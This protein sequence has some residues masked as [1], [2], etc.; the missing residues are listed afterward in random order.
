MALAETP[1]LNMRNHSFTPWAA[2]I[3]VTYN[4]GYADI[5]G[6]LERLLASPVAIYVID[7]WFSEESTEAIRKL[8]QLH[9]QRIT[10]IPLNKNYGIAFAINRG[11]EAARTDQHEYAMLF[12][13]DSLPQEGLMEEMHIVATR[14]SAG[15]K[16]VAAIGPRLYDPR[17]ST[18]FRFGLLRWGMWQRVGCTCGNGDLIRCEFLNSS[19]S[20]LFL[21]HWDQIG[22][23]REDFFIDHVETEWY[24]RVRHLGLECY[25]FC[26]PK[27]IDHH[28]GDSVCRYWLGKWR[29]MPRRSP[30]RHYTIVR[31]GI[32]MWR[33][34]HVPLSWVTNSGMKII[35][36]L[37]FFSLFDKEG[38]K[39]FD[40]IFKGICDGLFHHPRENGTI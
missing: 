2:C 5:S 35:F 30:L 27:H 9:P 23:F 21:R 10:F 40:F 38:K 1:S 37:V 13:Q 16:K 18:Y 26:S 4:P 14:L 24:M 15:N 22:P 12:D 34:N 20:L 29:F 39:Q 33:L 25:G 19:G 11:I 3:I 17:S 7:N 31:N 6:L 32:W 8:C 28:M 36:T